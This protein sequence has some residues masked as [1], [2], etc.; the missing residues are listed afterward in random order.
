MTIN[1]IILAF[2]LFITIAALYSLAG[3]SGHLAGLNKI[4]NYIIYWIP[5][6][7]LGGLLGSHL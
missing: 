6:V 5:A 4:N 3:F 2:F 1:H 7:V